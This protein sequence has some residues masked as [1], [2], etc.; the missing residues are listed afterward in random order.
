MVRRHNVSPRGSDPQR[1]KWSSGAQVP[2]PLP[3]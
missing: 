2:C 3:I 1:N